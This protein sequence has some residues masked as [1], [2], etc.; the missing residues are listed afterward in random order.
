MIASNPSMPKL[1]R[2]RDSYGLE[3]TW[4]TGRLPAEPEISCSSA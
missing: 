4:T 3:I 1:E 2:L